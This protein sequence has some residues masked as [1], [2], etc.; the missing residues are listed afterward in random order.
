MNIQNTLLWTY[1]DFTL[2]ISC[3]EFIWKEKFS[4]KIDIDKMKYISVLKWAG[5]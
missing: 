5:N 2:V 1:N 3:L 4:V